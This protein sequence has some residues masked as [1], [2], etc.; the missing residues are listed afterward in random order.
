MKSQ[1]AEII[2][3]Q[4]IVKTEKNFLSD[5]FFKKLKNIVEG[6]N[7]QWYFQNAT[8]PNY[9][10]EPKD[11][12]MFTH[13][14]FR[15]GRKSSDW[16]ETFEPIIYAINEKV[17]VNQLIRMKLNLYTNQHKNIK[18]AS[19]QDFEDK[20]NENPTIGLFN[21]TTC[22][23]GTNINKKVY[24]SKE[25]EILI[26]DNKLKHFGITQT[27]TPIRIVLNIGWK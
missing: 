8:V 7:F 17:K 11:N 16:F 1:T 23:G 27:H 20:E 15:E 14:L 25:N 13:N 2:D 5:M 4:S 12:F 19:H 18:H 21:F 9:K 26:Y 6:Y 3:L 10:K 22:N 24:Q